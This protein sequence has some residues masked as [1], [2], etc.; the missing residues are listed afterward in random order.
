MDDHKA[1]S[2]VRVAKR[3]REPDLGSQMVLAALVVAACVAGIPPLIDTVTQ[4]IG[5]SK[6][7][8]GR[9]GLACGACGVVENVHEVTL[10]AAKHKVSTVS[11]DGLAMFIG[12]LTGKL[13]TGPVKIYEVAVRLQDGSVRVFREGK[14]SAWKQGDRVKV[15]MGHIKALS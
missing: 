9:V 15:S 12:L 11:G 5:R 7:D 2:S 14:S 13:G 4:A 1:R 10:D 8:A 6:S 3:H